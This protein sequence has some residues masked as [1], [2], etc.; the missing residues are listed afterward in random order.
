MRIKYQDWDGTV[1]NSSAGIGVLYSSLPPS[2]TAIM[3][4]F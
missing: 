1:A 4:P 3:S 2:E